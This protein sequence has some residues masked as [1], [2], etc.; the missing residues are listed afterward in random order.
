[1]WWRLLAQL[2]RASVEAA[3]VDLFEQPLIHQLLAGELSLTLARQFPELR[4]CQ[5]RQP[6]GEAALSQGMRELVA[7]RGL[8]DPRHVD[9]LRPLLG[10]WTRCRL[11]TPEL[12]ADSSEED[13]AGYRAAL[14]QALRLTRF[15]GSQAL[16]CGRESQWNA[17]FF[18]AAI[19]SSE[20]T[21]LM[22]VAAECLPPLDLLPPKR[23][24]KRL[25]SPA[26]GCEP[27]R[28]AI[29]RSAWSRRSDLLA[30]RYAGPT[31]DIELNIGRD[32]LF[33]GAWEL[34]VRASGQL[35]GLK[36]AWEEVCWFSDED[37]D[38]LELECHLDHDLRIQR[39]F[40]LTRRDRVLLLADAVLGGTPHKLDYC[41]KLPL[42]PGVAFLPAEETHEGRIIARKQQTL[43]L[44]LALPEW[45]SGPRGG[46]LA[47]NDGRLELRQSATARSLFAPLFFDL[48]RRRRK[49]PFTWR[50]LTVADERVIQPQDVACGYRVQVG[51]EQWLIYRSLAERRARTLLGHHVNTE[52]LLGRF[53]RQGQVQQ[54]IEVE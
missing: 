9:L 27:A 54:L 53:N 8:T 34:S 2:V 14:L 6:S 49:R 31:V 29:L 39:Q 32:R 52:F 25:P 19:V 33:C 15:D 17:E 20:A 47:L 30:V 26:A 48:D 7:E 36:R 10:C 44:P 3:D 23:G 1:M 11:I 43:V 46:A 38:Y 24:L 37:V 4:A 5:A 28:F 12:A 45:R 13:G 41:S 42:P 16:T 35:A 21:D 40:A 50:R 51:G 18:R 22:H